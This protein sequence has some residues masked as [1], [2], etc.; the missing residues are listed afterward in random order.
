MTLAEGERLIFS[1]QTA[2]GRLVLTDL[3]VWHSSESEFTSIRLEDVSSVAVLQLTHR[4]LL[5]TTAACTTLAAG[6]VW[7]GSQGVPFLGTETYRWVASGLLFVSAILVMAF[8]TKRFT[9]M[10]I[11]AHTATIEARIRSMIRK[12]IIKLVR[13][14]EDAKNARYRQIGHPHPPEV[15]EG[16]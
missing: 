1:L 13:D 10:R 12:E 9:L 15:V 14:L 6:L 16:R 3:R 2:T 8:G 5:W 4:W 7:M 11:A